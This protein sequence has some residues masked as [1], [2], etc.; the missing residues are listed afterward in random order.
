MDEFS[1]KLGSM[2]EAYIVLKD[3]PGWRLQQITAKLRE[4]EG[5]NS[6][7]CLADVVD[8]AIPLEFVPEEVT[9]RYVRRRL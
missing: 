5:V 9:K 1:E 7:E 4:M 6:A 3:V 8:P 2:Q